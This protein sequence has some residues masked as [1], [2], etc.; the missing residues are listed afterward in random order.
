MLTIIEVDVGD[1]MTASSILAMGD[2]PGAWCS[3]GSAVVIGALRQDLVV[4]ANS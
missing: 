3:W 4:E 2:V 1:G